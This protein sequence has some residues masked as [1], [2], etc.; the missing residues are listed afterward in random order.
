MKPTE[1]FFE[2]D[3][4]ASGRL[5][6]PGARILLLGTGLMLTVVWMIFLV[7]ATGKVLEFL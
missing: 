2:P 7:W 1:L 4:N 3:T 6:W 5:K